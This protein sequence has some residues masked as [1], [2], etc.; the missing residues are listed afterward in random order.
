MDNNFR[1]EF[2]DLMAGK[3]I[4]YVHGFGSSGQSGTVTLLRQLM[5]QVTVV[6]P[7]VPLVPSEA[8]EL[9]HKTAEEEKPD[10][11]IGSSC[12]GMYA[13]QLRGF[14]RILIN[15]AFEIGETM[16]KHGMVGKNV[17]QNPRR[18]GVQEFIVT[19]A[20]VKEYGEAAAR[21]FDGIDD[22]DRRRVYSLFGDKD[23]VVN[24]FD[25]FRQHYDKAIRFHGGHRLEDH[26]AMH[27]LVPV[28]RWIDDAQQG[29]ERSV[30][31]IAA[32]ALADSYDK[33][34]A[35][36]HKAYETLIE[37]YSVIIVAPAP[38]DDHAALTH[39]QEWVEEYLNAP[40]YDRIIFANQLQ[41]LYGDYLISRREHP[42][43]MGTTLQLG[44]A[45]FKTWEE[46]ITFF[47]RL[48]GQ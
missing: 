2:P 15:P 29:R 9:L 43:F 7:D 26:V 38:T 16:T 11:I 44:S 12:G 36:L 23:P 5:P 14:D 6:A 42:E 21:C 48:G 31:F 17:Y 4:L 10:L 32:D 18:D 37:T 3:K 22:D 30:V 24:T 25:I 39:C 45:D 28:I 13:E 47:S 19:K 33:P 40:A 46:V 34:M 20:L 27:Y 1:K 41:L 8:L 35:S